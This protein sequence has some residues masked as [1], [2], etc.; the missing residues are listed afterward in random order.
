MKLKTS[1]RVHYDAGPNMTPLVDVVMVILIFLMLTGTFAVGEHFL[2]SNI[3]LTNKGVGGEKPPSG[4]PPDEPLEIRVDSTNADDWIAQV[5]GFMIKNT[6]DA[7][8]GRAAMQQQLEKMRDQFKSN[9]I[10]LDRVQVIIGPG[11]TT[12]YKH[13]IEIYQAALSA[14]FPKVAF[15]PAH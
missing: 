2:K 1:Q 3:P 14:E 13:L 6:S 9:G 11:S 8:A 10:A 4:L 5:G 15:A 12:R 7:R